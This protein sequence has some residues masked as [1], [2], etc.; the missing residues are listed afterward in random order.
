MW[1]FAERR[2]RPRPRGGHRTSAR[3]IISAGS[4]VC[5][6][7]GLLG[8]E[9]AAGTRVGPQGAT[10]S[11][12]RGHRPP[13]SHR[14][15]CRS[16]FPLRGEPCGGQARACAWCPSFRD[17]A[18]SSDRCR[19][20][21]AER[22]DR[23]RSQTQCPRRRPGL[24]RS[25]GLHR[26]GGSARRL[27]FPGD[28]VG[29]GRALVKLFWLQV[30]NQVEAARARRRT[31][32]MNAGPCWGPRG[33]PAW[34]WGRGGQGRDCQAP[35]PASL[36]LLVHVH[37]SASARTCALASGSTRGRRGVVPQRPGSAARPKSV[38]DSDWLSLNVA[39][40]ERGRGV[41]S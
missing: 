3:V 12:L 7:S 11:E 5:G 19:G 4:T 6:C 21:P 14:G 29:V 9:G 41:G 23:S 20:T 32:C 8:L 35:R 13:V 27:R 33:R 28:E 15:L 31:C 16:A 2:Q 39:A 34:R 24:C 17:S 30:T 40:N 26:L 36:L 18:A 10:A 1:G 37:R 22:P 38:K 25:L